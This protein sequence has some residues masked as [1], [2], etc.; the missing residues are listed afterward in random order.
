MERGEPEQ[1]RRKLDGDHYADPVMSAD[2]LRREMEMNASEEELLQAAIMHRK[3]M[4]AEEKA[5]QRIVVS[6]NQSY[7]PIH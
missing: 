2:E 6:D 4:R 5:K 3:A 7:I 1:K